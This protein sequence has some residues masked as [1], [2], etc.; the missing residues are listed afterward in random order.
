MMCVCAFVLPSSKTYKTLQ[1]RSDAHAGFLDLLHVI[2]TVPCV[3]I[4]MI[5]VC[6][7]IMWLLLVCVFLQYVFVHISVCI[8]VC[9]LLCYSYT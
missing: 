8:C 7:C 4:C 2:S 9:I 5:F 1:I 3:F 6:V